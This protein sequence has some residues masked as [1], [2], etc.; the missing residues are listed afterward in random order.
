[1]IPQNLEYRAA[2]LVGQC[3]QHRIHEG[4]VPNRIRNRKGTFDAGIQKGHSGA[5]GGRTQAAAECRSTEA[6]YAH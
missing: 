6:E 2:A 3:L 5:A 4:N 1:M